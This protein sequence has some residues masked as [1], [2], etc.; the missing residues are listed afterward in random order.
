MPLWWQRLPMLVLLGA[1]SF[2]PGRPALADDD[3]LGG[4]PRA[5][6]AEE[7][8]YLCSAC[9][10]FL[11]VAQQGLSRERWEETMV[12]MVEEQE[13]EKPESAQLRLIVDYLTKYYGPDRLARKMT[14]QQR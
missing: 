5:K 12:W 1:I 14:K 13:M 8:Y 3:E 10:S 4:I 2:A 6:G 11:L 9:H 7:T